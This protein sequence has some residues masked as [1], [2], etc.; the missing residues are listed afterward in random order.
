MNKETAKKIARTCTTADIN[1]WNG[2]VVKF[3]LELSPHILKAE[4]HACAACPFRHVV[5][6]GCIEDDCPIRMLRKDF[7]RMQSRTSAR[8]REF[9]K[10]KYE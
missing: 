8:V 10:A 3:V 2:A 1:K 7:Y 9:H 4:C 6:C 5:V